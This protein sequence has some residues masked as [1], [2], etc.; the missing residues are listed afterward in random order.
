MVAIWFL[1]I[2]RKIALICYLH[3]RSLPWCGILQKSIHLRILAALLLNASP[4]SQ[5][6]L[7]YLTIKKDRRFHK[8]MRL[9]KFYARMF[10]YPQIRHIMTACHTEI[11][12]IS[13]MFG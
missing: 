10:S 6:R 5:T 11:C 7:S 1:G 13:S 9:P 8:E 2:P 3:V 4:L 12:R